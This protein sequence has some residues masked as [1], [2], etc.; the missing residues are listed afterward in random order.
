MTDD[1]L[2]AHLEELMDA[3]PEM[4]KKGDALASAR[5][6]AEVAKRAHYL[7][8]QRNELDGILSAMDEHAQARDVAIAAGDAEA[9]GAHRAQVLLLGNERGIRKGAFEAA[10]RELDQA[11]SASGF[12]NVDEARSAELSESE[13]SALSAEVEAFQAGYAETL[14]A[15]QAVENA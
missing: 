2:F 4:Q 5:A 7:E 13:L 12:A 6:A 14:A 10:Q 9:E 3:L 8:G 11:L 1:E 15:C